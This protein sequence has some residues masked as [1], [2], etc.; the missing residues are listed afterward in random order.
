[1]TLSLLPLSEA[2]P[3]VWMWVRICKKAWFTEWPIA[4]LNI[5]NAVFDW[6]TCWESFPIEKPTP[7]VKFIHPRFAAVFRFSSLREGDVMVRAHTYFGWRFRPSWCGFPFLDTPHLSTPHLSTLHSGH[8]VPQWRCAIQD[9]TSLNRCF[10]SLVLR[11]KV[12]FI[13]MSLDIAVFVFCNNILDLRW[14]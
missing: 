13:L 11:M 5:Q 10:A 9:D 8:P 7:C 2:Q 3:S 1:M 14:D 4:A 6:S 12:I